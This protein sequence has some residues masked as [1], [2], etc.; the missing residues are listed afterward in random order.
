MLTNRKEG[1]VSGMQWSGIC[2]AHVYIEKLLKAA[3]APTVLH[4]WP[5]PDFICESVHAYTGNPVLCSHIA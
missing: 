5:K 2:L 1:R 4:D 3:A